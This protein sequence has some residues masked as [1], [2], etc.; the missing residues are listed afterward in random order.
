LKLGSKSV[1]T[2]TMKRLRSP[3]IM[4]LLTL[5]FSGGKN[6]VFVGRIMLRSQRRVH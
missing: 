5:T 6:I 3:D 1:I 4:L 2:A